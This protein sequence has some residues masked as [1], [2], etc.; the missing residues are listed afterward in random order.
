MIIESY[1]RTL[2]HDYL[3]RFNHLRVDLLVWILTF[4]VLPN[5][6]HRMK[7]ISSGQFRIF[8][9]RWRKAFKKQWEKEA[10]KAVD[11]EKLKEHHTY[12]VN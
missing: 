12:P 5:A 4:R 1:W 6:V 9:A 10:Y 2:K 3:Y 11:P 7:A 8:K